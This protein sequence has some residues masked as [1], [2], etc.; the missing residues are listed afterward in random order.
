MTATT[1]A[2]VP[3]LFSIGLIVLC[4]IYALE[5]DAERKKTADLEERCDLQARSLMSMAKREEL[6]RKDVA[7]LKG[8]ADFRIDERGYAPPP[9]VVERLDSFAFKVKNGI[10]PVPEFTKDKNDAREPNVFGVTPKGWIVVRD[11]GA[12]PIRPESWPDLGEIA[13]LVVTPISDG[14]PE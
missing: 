9:A 6:L 8:K 10:V 1:I 4:I 14:R 11:F 2:I 3:A 5:L 13:P 7:R 12:T